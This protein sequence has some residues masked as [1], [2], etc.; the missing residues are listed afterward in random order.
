VFQSIFVEESVMKRL[1]PLL[2]MLFLS[3]FATTA[4][5][6][7]AP[8]QPSP[9]EE[10]RSLHGDWKVTWSIG[11]PQTLFGET[12]RVIQSLQT[13]GLE[14]KIEENRLS[15]GCTRIIPGETL[16]LCNELPESLLRDR[17]LANGGP[18]RF[19][20]LTTETGKG[21]LASY[22]LHGDS[23]TLRYPAGCCSRSGNVITLT[24]VK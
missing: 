3:A 14:V 16:T 10:L 9:A 5:A 1:L 20:L 18:G 22:H 23:V 8:P 13:S 12:P 24:K 17:T 7:D 15:F 21:L 6:E 4:V 19:V 11:G 2:S